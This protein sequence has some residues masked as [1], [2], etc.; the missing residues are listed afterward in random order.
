MLTDITIRLCQVLD[1]D[2]SSALMMLVVSCLKAFDFCLPDHTASG[3]TLAAR[4]ENFVISHFS[5]LQGH[6]VALL[7]S[8]FHATAIALHWDALTAR[9]WQQVHS[10]KMA[11]T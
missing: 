7:M 1:I 2:C 11:A 4:F 3:F 9:T 5:G 6:K 10:M 8:A